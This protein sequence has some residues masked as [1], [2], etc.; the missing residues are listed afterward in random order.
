[1]TNWCFLG[2]M[3]G[4]GVAAYHN[5]HLNYCCMTI[6]MESLQ[7]FKLALQPPILLIFR[8]TKQDM[9]QAS[10][11]QGTGKWNPIVKAFKITVLHHVHL[12]CHCCCWKRN[13][14][15][16]LD[17]L[18]KEIFYNFYRLHSLA[19]QGDNVLGRVRLPE[20]FHVRL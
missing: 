4:Q 19:K 3:L 8:V 14:S 6:S 9:I 17:K 2:R 18:Q 20:P 5:K 13:G 10:S 11:M 16:N 1:M 15:A 12:E 7:L